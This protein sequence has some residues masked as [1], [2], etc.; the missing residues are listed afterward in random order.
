MQFLLID[1]H[2]LIVQA[3][4]LLLKTRFPDAVV[5]TGG[6]AAEARAL[7]AR[8]GESTDLVI[9]DLN[10]P[11]VTTPT[12]LLEELVALNPALKIL[13]LSGLVDAAS[14]TRVLQ[15]GAAG[16]VP[17]TLDTGML[18]RAIDFV[19]Q[20][21]VYIPSRLLSEPQKAGFISQTA[22]DLAP[23]PEPGVH[24]TQRQT[25]VLQ[26]LA[27]GYPIKRIC[28]ELNL[29]EG[30]VKTHVAAIY[31]AFGAR[32]RTEALIG[33]KRAGFDILI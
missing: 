27:R 16:F 4:S 9:L 31:R 24:L 2:A 19:L 28:R 12:S 14:I 1:D 18:T 21:G 33:A 13:V 29:S 23:Q 6:T 10:V 17:K 30:T 26:A 3:L 22:G 11:G 25:D 32:N 7:A 5:H 15:L 8:H 20:G